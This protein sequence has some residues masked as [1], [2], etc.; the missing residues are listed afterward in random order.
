MTKHAARR[1]GFFH[2]VGIGCTVC[3]CPWFAI[4]D[5]CTCLL[6]QA[7]KD[8]RITIGMDRWELCS[9]RPVLPCDWDGI[10]LSLSGFRNQSLREL[11]YVGLAHV[12]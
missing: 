10:S 6:G 12:V 2:G 3:V 5:R 7:G 4:R 11:S 9:M 8:C 1:A